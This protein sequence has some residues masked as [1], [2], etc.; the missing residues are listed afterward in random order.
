M[1]CNNLFCKKQC[2]THSLKHVK[3]AVLQSDACTCNAVIL[4][5]LAV[6][7]ATSSHGVLIAIC[8]VLQVGKMLLLT[9]A[10]GMHEFFQI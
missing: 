4:R 9:A 2:S 3:V 5:L 10:R 7:V 6:S 1:E 8:M